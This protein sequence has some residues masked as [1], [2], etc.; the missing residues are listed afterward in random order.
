MKMIRLS[1]LCLGMLITANSV[2]QQLPPAGTPSVAKKTDEKQPKKKPGKNNDNIS[3]LS[4][5]GGLGI[6]NYVGDLIKGNTAFQQSSFSSSIGL[7][8]AFI[9]NLA[10]RFDIG[11]H[12]VQGYDSKEGGAHPDRNLSFRS[13]IIEFAL[14]AEF[15]LMNMDKHKFSPYLFAGIGVFNFNPRAYYGS[16]GTHGLRELGTEGQG[17]AGYPGLYSTMAVEYPLGFGFKYAINKKIMLQFEFNYRA[18]GTD[19]LDDVS[20]YYPDKALLDAKNPNTSK[21]T[22]R[23]N[24]PYP[25]NPTLKRGDAGNKDG[26]YTTQLKLAYKLQG[27]KGKKTAKTEVKLPVKNNEADRDNDGTA[28]A[29]DKCPDVAGSKDNSGCPFPFI[30]GSELSAVSPD[31]M[32]YRIYFDLDRSML[33]SDAFKTLQGIVAILKADNTLSVNIS[34]H[35]DNTG[36][37]AAN[38]QISEERAKITR[39]YFMSYNIPAEK[40]TT[41]HYGETMPVDETQQWRN[42]R[43]EITIIKK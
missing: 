3:K 8:Y 42:R 39:D 41:A 25:K 9:P 23:G 15:T 34:G 1:I 6:A 22:F 40:I 2:G 18:S 26:Y 21:F 36:T 5:T 33:L 4:I 27:N 14:A 7:N 16:G 13:R 11:Y 37:S 12:N 35:S 32:T 30:D 10:A 20:T 24:G 19:Y 29:F 38:M 17:L 43:V 28:D 31:S